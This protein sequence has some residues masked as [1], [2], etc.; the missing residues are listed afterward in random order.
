[1]NDGGDG[2]DERHDRGMAENEMDEVWVVSHTHVKRRGW[3]LME[4]CVWRLYTP[5]RR[6]SSILAAR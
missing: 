2:G 1:V 3:A 6:G 4:Y 5:C